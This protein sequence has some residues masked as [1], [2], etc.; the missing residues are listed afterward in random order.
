M[1]QDGQENLFSEHGG[2]VYYPVED[3]LTRIND[4]NIVLETITNRET[5]LNAKRPEKAIVNH[6]LQNG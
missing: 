5:Y 6:Q 3:F 2:K 1:S 4:P